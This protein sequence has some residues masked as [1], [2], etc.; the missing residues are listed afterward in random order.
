MFDDRFAERHHAVSS[1]TVI[2]QCHPLRGHPAGSSPSVSSAP[3]SSRRVITF[4]VIRSAVIPQGHHLRCHPL[5]G[6]HTKCVKETFSP[7]F[8]SNVEF[9]FIFA[10][11]WKSRNNIFSRKHFNCFCSL[12]L[13][14]LQW[15]TLQKSSVSQRRPCMRT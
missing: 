6:H 5:R 13:R 15:M 2:T 7:L 12:G 9:V 8:V 3:R 4:G 14:A 11:L 1:G 10:P